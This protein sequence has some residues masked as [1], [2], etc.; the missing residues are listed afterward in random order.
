MF[1]GRFCGDGSVRIRVVKW[2]YNG[3][4]QIKSDALELEVVITI[5]LG[6]ILKVDL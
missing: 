2:T 1:A 6:S 3:D 5:L 4:I